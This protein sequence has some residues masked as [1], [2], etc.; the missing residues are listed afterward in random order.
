MASRCATANYQQTMFPNQLIHSITNGVH[1]ATWA[2]APFQELY[3]RHI[4]E[5]RHDNLYLRYAVGIGVR[6]DPE[7][8]HTGQTRELLGEIKK[9]NWCI[10]LR[11]RGDSGFCP[12]GG[13]STSGLDLLFSD[14]NRLARH[15]ENAGPLQVVFGGKAHPWDEAGGAEIR[16]VFEAAAALRDVIPVVYV[17]DY[18]LRWAQLF[19]VPTLTF[20]SIRPT[21][22]SRPPARVA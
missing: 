10:A 19:T 14:L 8:A 5:W 1:A 16:K 2:S 17:S 20:G 7:S 15:S 21:G 4:P 12:K 9:A 13:R 11:K 22:R 3:D 6:R 18:D